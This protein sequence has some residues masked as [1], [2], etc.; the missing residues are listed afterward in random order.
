MLLRDLVARVTVQADTTAIRTLDASMAKFAST[1]GLLAKGALAAFSAAAVDAAA[2]ADWLKQQIK[3]RTQ[4]TQQ[5]AMLEAAMDKVASAGRGLFKDVEIR[6]GVL[7]AQK[8]GMALDDIVSTLAQAAVLYPRAGIQDFGELV[9]SLAQAKMGGPNIVTE[10]LRSLGMIG[11][12][13]KAILDMIYGQ[14]TARAG[15]GVGTIVGRNIGKSILDNVFSP[16]MMSKLDQELGGFLKSPAGQALTARK[17]LG[18]VFLKMADVVMNIIAPVFRV[19]N[20]DIIPPLKVFLQRVSELVGSSEGIGGLMDAA[21]KRYDALADSPWAN[22]PLSPHWFVRM[23][24]DYPQMFGVPLNKFLEWADSLG[25]T[26][27]DQPKTKPPP[28]GPPPSEGGKRG[29]LP[30]PWDVRPQSYSEQS[31]SAPKSGGGVVFTGDIIINA[32]GASGQEIVRAI[33]EEFGRMMRH[34]RDDLL[35]AQAVT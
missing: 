31:S 35:S 20:D 8:M 15:E 5:W 27:E 12:D 21:K 33:H 34:A 22:I 1:A 9:T 32:P 16:E 11:A 13:Q 23:S 24:R 28:A 10:F 14:I 29:S 25:R 26:L 19:L 6:S 7:E 17:N 30:L 4:D 18:D 3:M 2:R